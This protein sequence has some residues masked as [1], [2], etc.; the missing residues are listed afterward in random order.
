MNISNKV[1]TALYYFHPPNVFHQLNIPIPTIEVIGGWPSYQ[2]LIHI[3][4]SIVNL[5]KNNYDD[6]VPAN[7]PS[8]LCS[9]VNQMNA[10]LLRDPYLRIHP[11]QYNESESIS[12][13]QEEENFH[14]ANEYIDNNLFTY[15][16]YDVERNIEI[17]YYDYSDAIPD[18]VIY[19]KAIPLTLDCSSFV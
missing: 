13:P 3:D 6:L 10:T 1:S 16:D 11:T 7:Q 5:Q 12:T 2:P 9:L 18:K 19:G 15:Y 14:D 17:Q 4:P 8:Y